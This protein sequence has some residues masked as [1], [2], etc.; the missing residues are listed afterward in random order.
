[1]VRL[2]VDNITQQQHGR[3]IPFTSGML[4]TGGG[5]DSSPP[6]FT[7]QYGYFEIRARVPAGNGL[8]P[9]FWMLTLAQKT[10]EIDIMEILSRDPAR[11]H[12]HYHY[13]DDSGEEQDFGASW[14]GGDFSTGWHTFAVDWEPDAI[15]WY[16]DGVERNRFEGKYV[17][18]EPLYLILNLQVG[19]A[20]SWSGPADATTT[21]PAYFDIDYVRVWQ[22]ARP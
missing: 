1:M 6:R 19:G 12:L 13:T 11:V 18:A 14:S 8:W 5:S 2:R 4:S 21:F 16:V 22:R 15:I 17:A 10:P 3:A 7:P 20:D 9:A